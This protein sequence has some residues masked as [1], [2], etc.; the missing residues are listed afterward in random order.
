[1]TGLDLKIIADPASARGAPTAKSVNPFESTSDISL[2]REYPNPDFT[3][4]LKS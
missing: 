4:K 3:G 2:D 1:M